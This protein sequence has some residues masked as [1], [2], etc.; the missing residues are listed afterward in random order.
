MT[1]GNKTKNQPKP[2]PMLTEADVRTTIPMSQE[3]LIGRVVVAWSKLE[4]QMQALIW[5]F[6]GLEDEIGRIVTCR[7]DAT[8]KLTMLRDLG[9]KLLA[10]E[11]FEKFRESLKNIQ[12]LYAER[13]FIAHGSWG[14]T[15]KNHKPFAGSLKKKV[16]PLEG[17]PE[18]IIFEAFPPERMH[19]LVNRIVL[20][21]EMMIAL[22]SSLSPS[23]DKQL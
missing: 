5:A 18:N 1:N 2:L 22:R 14:T 21:K 20:M 3:R 12:D 15:I 13:N 4:D 23:R 6:L 16:P 19:R 9:S 7:L 10:S 17:D 8:Y 11:E